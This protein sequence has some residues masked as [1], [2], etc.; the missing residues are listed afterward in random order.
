VP[1][2]LEHIVEQHAEEAAF[3]WMLRDKAVDAPHYTPR[4]LAR[5][6]ERVEAN[7]DGLRLAGEAGQEIVTAALKRHQE[8]GELFAAAVPALE[9]GDPERVAPL[10]A[11]ADKVPEARRGFFGAIG[12][13]R[14]Q[15]LKVTARRWLEGDDPFGRCLGLVACSHHRADPGHRLAEWLDDADARVRARALRLAGELGRVDLRDAVAVAFAQDDDPA[16]R[17]WAAW[18]MGLLGERAGLPMLV[19]TAMA[20]TPASGHALQVAVRVAAPDDVRAWIRCLNSQALHR[21]CA[22][23]AAG[24]LGDPAAVPWLIDVMGEADLARVAGES[25]ALVTGVDLAREGLDRTQPEGFAARPTDD[26]SDEDVALDPDEHLPWPDVGRVAAW[27]AS[28]ATRFRTGERHLL[29]APIGPESVRQVFADGYQGQRRAAAY[30]LA[31]AR[32]G[33][34]SWRAR[35][36]GTPGL[37]A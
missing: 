6:D 23:K 31:T 4:Q 32:P 28:A 26:P 15:H 1:R 24:I 11:I 12:W 37:A 10:A 9:S 19:S 25:L 7:L 3:L 16:C 20:D 8:T 33:L 27:W 18:S 34:P 5:L 35:L 30:E 21:R 13:V 29:G 22:V 2:V 17:F 36:R 14:P